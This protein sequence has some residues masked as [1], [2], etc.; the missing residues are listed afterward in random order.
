MTDIEERFARNGDDG[1]L[2]ERQLFRRASVKRES[3]RR[4]T[5]SRLANLTPLRFLRYF[6]DDSRCNAISVACAQCLGI[7][8][9]G[10]ISAGLYEASDHNAASSVQGARETVEMSR[11]NF[12]A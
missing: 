6:T 5:K 3:R 12:F 4:P 8:E 2:I 10:L 9:I 1:S 7:R 11:A